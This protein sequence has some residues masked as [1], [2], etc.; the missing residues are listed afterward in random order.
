[1]PSPM[2]VSL[3]VPYSENEQQF[4]AF[5]VQ[6]AVRTFRSM[7]A[8]SDAHTLP[9]SFAG[10]SDPSSSAKHDQPAV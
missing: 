3:Q 6:I 7:H 10:P 2:T 9:L 4:L 8:R 5:A 1:M